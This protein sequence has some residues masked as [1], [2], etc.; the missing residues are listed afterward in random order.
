M[1][2]SR[3]FKSAILPLA[4]FFVF[5]VLSFA[6][7]E[8]RSFSPTEIHKISN[9]L[10]LIRRYY[11]DTESSSALAESAIM[12]LLSKLD[13]HSIYMPPKSV[14]RSDEEFSGNYE[15]VGIT[16]TKGKND[17]II[18]DGVTQGGPSDKVGL[19]A[20]DRIVAIEGEQV[21]AGEADS[22]S[23][24]LRGKRGTKVA[25]TVVRHGIANP[26]DFTITRDK[27]PIVSVMASVMI[28]KETGYLDIGRF[29]ATTHSE[30]MSAL[31]WLKAKGM[32]KL[33]LDLRGNPG[34]YMEQAV[35]IADEFI[36][37]GKTIVCAKGRLPVFDEYDISHSGQEF[38]KTPLVVLVDGGSAS[39]SEI[40]A[41]ALQ[42]LDRAPLVGTTTFGKGLVQRQFALEDGSAVRLTIARY[43]TPSGRSIQR[44]YNGSHYKVPVPDS[45]EDDDDVIEDPYVETAG[46]S[47][48]PKF[49]TPSGRTIF[50]GGGITPDMVIRTDT[51]TATT[52]KLISSSVIYD[53]VTDFVT[54][55]APTMKYL[56]SEESFANTFRL[57]EETYGELLARAQEKNITIVKEEFEH[58]RAEI[59]VL[60]RAEIGHE[61][62]GNNARALI[63]LQSDKQFQKA[64]SLLDEAEKMAVAF[65]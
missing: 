4:F 10:D 36:P 60:M 37:G 19:I 51:M 55:H 59:D 63:M 33:I 56:Y 25:V 45:D 21:R 7:S 48:R 46:D 8:G 41:G 49:I 28:D 29:S 26:I 53:Y 30:F 20:G 35:E 61:I 31:E 40:L 2:A 50:G 22:I 17:T 42:D 14:E 24:K 65:R 15:G 64:Y 18:V 9:V 62:F 32:Q 39:A 23:R 13:P 1:T 44:P 16:Y 38:E 47:V 34:G 43:Y 5:P 57:P 12:G 27:V 52:L 58:D 3:S 54:E 6:Q 11:V